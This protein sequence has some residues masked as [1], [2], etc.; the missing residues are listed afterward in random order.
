MSRLRQ[1]IA[2]SIESAAGANQPSLL[3]QIKYPRPT[4]V[5]RLVRGP[6]RAAR[7]KAVHVLRAYLPGSIWTH[8]GIRDFVNIE[9]GFAA[10]QLISDYIVATE[11]IRPR[12][13]AYTCGSA[14]VPSLWWFTFQQGRV[15]VRWLPHWLAPWGAYEVSNLTE[16]LGNAKT[17]GV[18]NSERSLYSG[19][20]NCSHRAIPGRL[21]R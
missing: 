15:I 14:K 17:A 7:P 12:R 3:P 19:S 11:F 16:T 13:R 5:S 4:R 8:S 1:A 20:A 10:A 18:E 2:G 21:H 9:G 6:W